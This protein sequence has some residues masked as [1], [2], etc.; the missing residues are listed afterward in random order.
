MAYLW[1]ICRKLV[2]AGACLAAAA[3]PDAWANSVGIEN[4]VSATSIQQ[5]V[6]LATN[7]DV[8]LIS[9]GIF[10]ESVCVAAKDLT[11]RGAFD[12][13]LTNQVPGGY[14]EVN[15]QGLG[16][17]FAFVGQGEGEKR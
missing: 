2:L 14:T 9:T 7:G 13:A 3:G 4:G 17:S 8:I 10:Y 12:E 15:A 11:F 16:N 5:A 1:S 6:D